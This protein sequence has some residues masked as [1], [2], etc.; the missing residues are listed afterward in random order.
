MLIV[1]TRRTEWQSG[2]RPK[3]Q[4]RRNSS[5]FDDGSIE[6]N[7]KR[8]RIMDRTKARQIL[9]PASDNRAPS[10]VSCP[11]SSVLPAT[12]QPDFLVVA[13]PRL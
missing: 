4:K 8:Q 13:T 1:S 11:Q 10:A 7:G 2:A 3:R 12:Q 9:A 6:E 5:D